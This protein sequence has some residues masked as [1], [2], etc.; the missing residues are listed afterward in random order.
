MLHGRGGLLR[1]RPDD[2]GQPG[3]RSPSFF[4][5]LLS[6]YVVTL[7]EVLVPSAVCYPSFTLLPK[8]FGAME[9]SE[10]VQ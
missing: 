5:S 9:I 8:C 7:Q 6:S 10:M 4:A 3:A 2:R 1:E